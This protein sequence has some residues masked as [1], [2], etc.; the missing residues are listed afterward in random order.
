MAS[1]KSVSEL[2]NMDLSIPNY[3]RP[4]KWESRNIIE[5]LSDITNAITDSAKYGDSFRYRVGTVILYKSETKE[6]NWEVVDGQQRVISLTLLMK[7][8][9][10]D[11]KNTIV[12]TKFNNRITQANINANY[13]MICDWFRY[14][15]D[16]FRQKFINALENV[17]EVVVLTVNKI[18]EAFQFFDSQNTRG[19]ALDPHDLLKAYHL[20]EMKNYQYEMEYAVKKWEDKDTDEIRELFDSYLYAIW[21]WSRGSKTKKFTVKDIDT[22]KGV[23]EDLSYTYAKRAS[24]ATPFYQITEPFVAG[25]DFFEMV[26]HYMVMLE[27]IQKELKN[28]ERFE[29]IYKTINEKKDFNERKYSKNLFICALMAYYD[30]FRN[31]DEMVVKK[32]F[33]WAY[34]IR[35]DMQ[36]LGYDTINKYAIG[37]EQ[38]SYTNNI[39]MFAKIEYARMHT[40]IANHKIETYRKSGYAADDK[41]NELYEKI[42]K[43][44]GEM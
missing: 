11:Y 32:L 3:Q 20:R 43:I 9:K 2:L 35:V 4:Y 16:D 42:R 8:L 26:E 13:K 7:C 40:E 5:L 14:R 22:Y 41:W 36:K 34:M 44:N 12:S 17:V 1:I 31:F 29:E 38:S 24:K 33:I 30:R 27:I 39:A 18:N 10:P 25:N 15:D 6:G 21:N 28:N 37:E 23:R 19:K